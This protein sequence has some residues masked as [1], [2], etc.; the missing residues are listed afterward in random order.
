MA[1]AV[2]IP[3]AV[4]TRFAPKLSA[5]GVAV[6]PVPLPR[7]VCEAIAGMPVKLLIE[8]AMIVPVPTGPKD[9]PLPTCKA[10]AVVFVP[11]VRVLNDTGG[12]VNHDVL[13]PLVVRMSPLLPICDGSKLFNAALAVDAF[14]PPLAIGTSVSPETAVPEAA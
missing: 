9:A 5:I 1:W 14:V 8:V 6:E 7:I 13:V 12:A 3:D 4:A 11:L 2:P 10:L